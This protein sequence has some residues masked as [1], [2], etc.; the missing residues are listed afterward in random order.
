MDDQPHLRNPPIGN[1]FF[2]VIKAVILLQYFAV[3]PQKIRHIF[4]KAFI[5]FRHGGTEFDLMQ[6]L[7]LQLFPNRI[8]PEISNICM[9]QGGINTVMFL[10]EVVQPLDC[11]LLYADV[12]EI[13]T[14][15][16]ILH[17]AFP[18][19]GSILSPLDILYPVDIF[20]IIYLPQSIV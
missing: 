19:S 20:Q 16:Q 12:E 10:L 1:I 17:N 15:P 4:F 6:I 3:C 8:F 7:I 18:L 9:I 14:D 5:G 11:L 13:I 2:S